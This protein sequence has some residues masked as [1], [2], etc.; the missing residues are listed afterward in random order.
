MKIPAARQATAK[1]TRVA[2]S[3]EWIRLPR[4]GER[5]PLT[6]LSR[7]TLNALILPT[8][9]NGNKPPVKS[10]VLKSSKFATRGVRLIHAPSLLHYLENQPVM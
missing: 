6:G 5:C 4:S 8:N 10:R 3:P 1:P 9:G 7:T 2:H